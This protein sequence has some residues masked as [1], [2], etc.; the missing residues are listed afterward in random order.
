MV[1]RVRRGQSFWAQPIGGS[2]ADPRAV[3]HLSGRRRSCRVF[4]SRLIPGRGLLS[5]ERRPV[6]PHQS[7]STP[8]WPP[9]PRSRAPRLMSFGRRS[10]PPRPR[11]QKRS[12]TGCQRSGIVAYSSC[13]TPHTRTTTASS[14]EPGG[15]RGTR[16]GAEA[17]LVRERNDPLPRRQA[18]P[19]RTRN[20]DR[21]GASRGDRGARPSL[22]RWRVGT[23][24][25]LSL[26]VERDFA[27]IGE[28]RRVERV[29]QRSRNRSTLGGA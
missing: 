12:P 26:K 27:Q 9:C 1:C 7:A 29:D 25:L 11:R 18:H 21:Q 6:W 24:S 17:L 23:P 15:H 14:R 8:T 22:R 10:G 20:K 5:H 16:G 28:T 19:F 13:P 3:H 2:V 4:E